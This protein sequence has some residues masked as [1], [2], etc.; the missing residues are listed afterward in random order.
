MVQRVKRHQR[1]GRCSSVASTTA[2]AG[3]AAQCK[4][5]TMPR[6]KRHPLQLHHNDV[7]TAVWQEQ[8]L[9]QDVALTVMA[10]Q[11]VWQTALA[12]RRPA[13]PCRRA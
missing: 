12:K 5:V 3:L 4:R 9:Q 11:L 1:H 13:W 6:S 8:Q 7:L 2:Q 10:C